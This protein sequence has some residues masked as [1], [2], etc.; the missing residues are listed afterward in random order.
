MTGNR[1][2]AGIALGALFG[3]LHA[4]W[5]TSVAAGSGQSLLTVLEAWHFLSS[6]YT[7]T[8]FDPVTAVAGVIGATVTGYLIGWV[9]TYMYDL[10]GEK[11]D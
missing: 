3:L 5:V 7:I 10:T 9:F 6:G 4:A 2:Q 1:N 8:A 11:L